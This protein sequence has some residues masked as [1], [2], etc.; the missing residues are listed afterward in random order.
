MR[1]AGKDSPSIGAS[2]YGVQ[3]TARVAA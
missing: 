3:F 2:P 1:E